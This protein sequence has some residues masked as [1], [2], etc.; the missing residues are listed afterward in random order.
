VDV[1]LVA[2]GNELVLG[3]TVDTNGAEIGRALAGAGVRVVRRATVGDDPG[4][5]RDAVAD[6]LR[7][8]GVVITTGGLGPTRDD[9]TKKVVADLFGM[10]LVFRDDIWAALLERYAP[11]GRAPS[12]SNR[13][14][15]EVPEG[16]VVLRNRRGTAPGLWLERDGLGLAIMMPGVPIEMRMMLADEVAPRLAARAGGGLVTR[17]RTVRCTAIPESTLA[18][19]MGEIEA[20][21][22]PLTLAYLP[23]AEG[24]DMRLTAWNLPPADADERLARAEARLRER[25][26]A[27]AYGAD[28]DDLAALVLEAARRRGARLA[29][30]ES[31]TG[32]LVGGRLTAI[33]GSSDVFV[34]G[35]VAYSNAVKTAFLDVSESLL[36]AHGAVSE[37][38]ARAMAEGAVRRLGAE[39]A[40]SVTGIAGPGGGSAEKPVGTVWI[41]VAV[42]GAGTTAGRSVFWGN[43]DEIRARAAQTALYRVWE[44]LEGRG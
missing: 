15:A 12:E 16:A 13:T 20:E 8:T 5:I 30:A 34:G 38:V 17:S 35:V 24:V 39:Y 6:A 14:Q 10:P 29:A 36:A 33:P 22:A 40:V 4:A 1:E 44:R 27:H 28:D 19:R 2:V 3:F 41:A 9:V 23:G 7:R 31:C 32:G 18:E 21:I 25:A 37:P 42:D 11:L 43:R 26:G